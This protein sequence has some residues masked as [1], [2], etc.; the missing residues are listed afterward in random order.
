MLGVKRQKQSPGAQAGALLRREVREEKCWG[1][2]GNPAPVRS[3]LTGI[4]P[5]LNMLADTTGPGCPLV[6]GAPS[7]DF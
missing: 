4:V 1:A 7:M 6:V 2:L 5:H 3:P